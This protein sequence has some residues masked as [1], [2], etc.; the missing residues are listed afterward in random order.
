MNKLPHRESGV[1][2]VLVLS[3]AAVLG[4]LVLQLALTAKSQ[5]TRAQSLIDRAEADL[6]ARSASADL[7]FALL[8]QPWVERDSDKSNNE[9]AT[10]LPEV[11]NFRA[12]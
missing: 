11:W 12:D 4:L 6:A 9:T 2:L 7:S 3:L 10:T 8:T 1:A 5:A